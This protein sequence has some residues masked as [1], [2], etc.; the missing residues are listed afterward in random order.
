[1]MKNVLI[2]NRE[3]AVEAYTESM[4]EYHKVSRDGMHLIEYADELISLGGDIN[5]LLSLNLETSRRAFE[6]AFR[7]GFTMMMLPG[8]VD[9][10]ERWSEAGEDFQVVVF[11][12]EGRPVGTFSQD[13][14]Q[15]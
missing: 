2:V 4:T 12:A 6:G 8:E 7:A 14:V 13:T 9:T 5:R 11:T 3:E 1:M 15:W 10:L